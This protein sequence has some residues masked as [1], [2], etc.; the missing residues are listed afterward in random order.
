MTLIAV[1]ALN[2][3]DAREAAA[4]SLRDGLPTMRDVSDVGNSRSHALVNWWMLGLT[5][6]LLLAQTGQSGSR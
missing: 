2:I 4:V 3:V 6:V 5:C 1:A